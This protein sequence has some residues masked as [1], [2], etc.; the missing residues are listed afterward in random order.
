[1]AKSKVKD[2]RGNNYVYFAFRSEYD[3]AVSEIM[4]T[5]GMIDVN[6]ATLFL[7]SSSFCKLH[8]IYIP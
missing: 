7:Y 5:N 2:F 3:G 8:N 4:L 6:K 1:M